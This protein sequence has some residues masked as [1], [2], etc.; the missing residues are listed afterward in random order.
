MRGPP[1]DEA[2]I[3][4]RV[5]KTLLITSVW[6]MLLATIKRNTS[7]WDAA[8]PI[9]PSPMKSSNR[10]PGGVTHLYP[11]EIASSPDKAAK[12]SN[13][14]PS[15]FKEFANPRAYFRVRPDL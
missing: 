15:R 2:G 6:G 12:N 14:I 13:S 10:S 11:A 1:Q 4:A 5:R 9:L 8:H 7:T 3:L